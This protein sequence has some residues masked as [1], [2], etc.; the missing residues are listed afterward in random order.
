M[1]VTT[2]AGPI[3]FL[4]EGR[5][6]R[7]VK[8]KGQQ[9]ATNPNLVRAL[10]YPDRESFITQ[11]AVKLYTDPAD[12]NSWKT[13]MDTPLD[14][15]TFETSRPLTQLFLRNV[16]FCNRPISLVYFIQVGRDH[17]CHQGFAQPK[18]GI[19]RDNLTVP[20]DRVCPDFTRPK[21]AALQSPPTIH[22]GHVK[23]GYS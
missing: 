11:N 22:S 13:L 14:I 16:A 3:T 21:A 2:Q 19:N 9:L 12:R 20:V 4:W 10:G 1:A 23:P 15:A 6:K 5:D 17:A 18:T 7:G 8:L